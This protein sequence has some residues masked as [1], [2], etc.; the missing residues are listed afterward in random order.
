[1][2]MHAAKILV[3]GA[4]SIGERHIRAFRQIKSTSVGLVD[5]RKER[6]EQ[7]AARYNCE[8]YFTCLDS[9]PPDASFD[10]AVI[11]SP[12]NSHVDIATQCAERRL[13][14]LIEKPLAASFDGVDS[15]IAMCRE[16]TLTAAV[17]YILRFDAT[18]EKLREIV[19][20]GMLGELISVQ[21]ICTHY[22]PH[23]RPDYRQAY[24]TTENAGAGVILDLSHELNYLEWILGDLQLQAC[25][26]AAVKSLDTADEAV[27]DLWL[28]SSAG[29]L[30]QI[31]LHAADR[32][33]RRECH[34]VGSQATAAANLL[35]GEILI[36]HKTEKVE[37]FKQPPERDDWHLLQAV[38]FIE[39]I[40][41]GHPPRCTLQE[42][43][44]TLQV[45]LKA[46][47]S[48]LLLD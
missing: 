3:I 17:G 28:R 40:R 26:R 5:P 35:T 4:G 1:M 33:I 10:A 8:S 22:L 41:D 29:T 47:M 18:V 30:V 27:A 31:H 12:A 39:S 48:P 44:R 37:R 19:V 23:S 32:N 7:I 2:N 13:H 24:Y 36:I 34:V 15:L 45:C 20:A 42:A 38:N 9:V 11:A 6:A 25:R 21:S 16:R 43:S 46:M 14:L